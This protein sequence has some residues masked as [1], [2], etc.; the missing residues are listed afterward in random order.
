MSTEVT[1]GSE[2]DGAGWRRAAVLFVLLV[3]TSLVPAGMLV[4]VPLLI[5]IG[6]GGIRSG[7][8]L[9]TTVLAMLIVVAG[10]R[11]PLWYAERGWAVMLGGFFAAATILV[12]RWRLTS[13]SLVAVAGSVVGAAAFYAVRTGAW[14][15][16]D[17]S[18]NDR[19]AGVLGN[20]LY[21]LEVVREGQAVSPAFVAAVYRTVELQ[22]AVFPA[23]VALESMAAL[24]VAWWLYRRL[25]F[26][27]DQ[28]LA[29]VRHF[30]FND[31]LVWVLITGLVLVV[32]R[33]GD[34]AVRLGANLAVFMTAL[35]ALRGAG[36]VV[37]VNGGLSLFGALMFILGVLFAA[38]VVIGFAALL[39]IAD[40]WL[41]L[42]A[43]AEAM[44]G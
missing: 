41:D 16:L 38:P 10:Q 24:G 2:Q 35:Y 15:N 23:V 43:R 36:V 9:V 14:A 25:V 29:P 37:F 20:F 3:L 28:G 8:L 12:P 19:L 6:L 33:L 21:A 34:G 42:R 22:A 27:D 17:W 13:R 32:T 31:H 1:A 11:D 40:T 39:G 5:L 44:A 26:R 30:A 4:A 18:V 7:A